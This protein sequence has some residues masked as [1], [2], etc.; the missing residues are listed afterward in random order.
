MLTK[1]TGM[2][3]SS[4][5][6]RRKIDR[7]RDSGSAGGCGNSESSVRI[8]ERN[9]GGRA[10]AE[11]AWGSGR[12]RGG[13]WVVGGSLKK[14]SNLRDRQEEGKRKLLTESICYLETDLDDPR[15]FVF[16]PRLK[17]RRNARKSQ[18]LKK[19]TGR[20]RMKRKPK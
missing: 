13:Q 2:E 11:I 20:G 5:R 8:A 4:G 12:R 10:N 3:E 1:G 15:T 9:R 14:N 7:T 19:G 17:A 16:Y 18:K 6:I